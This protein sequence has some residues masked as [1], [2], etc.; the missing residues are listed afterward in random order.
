M[1]APGDF[2]S[3]DVLTAAD[4]NGVSGGIAMY[5]ESTATLTA[6][7]AESTITSN[8]FTAIGSRPYV[9]TLSTP[10]F[11][12]SATECYFYVRETTSTGTVVHQFFS[13]CSG[14]ASRSVSNT[15]RTTFTAG[16]VTLF[17]R[18]LPVG[19]NVTVPYAANKKSLMVVM[20][21]GS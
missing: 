17:Y 18:V 13:E 7:T 2:T 11:Y 5:A 19:G 9:I 8:A 1:T 16:S 12:G 21:G 10:Q 14:T 20:D 3:G 15:F 4:M 6:V